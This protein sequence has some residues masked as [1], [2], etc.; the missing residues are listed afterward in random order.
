MGES[1]LIAAAVGATGGV[2][3][4]LVALAVWRF[5]RGSRDLGSDT[6]QATYRTLHLA[7][8]AAVHV[9][10]D[11]TGGQAERAARHLRTLLGCESLAIAHAAGVAVDGGNEVTRLAASEIAGMNFDDG[12]TRV[13][14]IA[15]GDSRWAIV[16]PI[17]SD[18]VVI[19]AIIAFTAARRAPLVRAT[20]EVSEWVA[21]QLQLGELQSSR[22]ALAEAEL[23]A[24]RSQI[25]PHF[26]YNALNAIA[27]FILTDPPHARD[28]VLEFADY[29]RYS[30]RRVGEFTTIAE[31][32][33]SI[34]S[35]LAIERA[36]F[37][38]RL[39]VSLQVAPEVLTAV[40]PFLSV[41][42][43]VENAVRHGLEQQGGGRIRIVA[44]E[45]GTDVLVTVEDNGSGIDPLELSEMLGRPA[46][47][48]HVGLRN[49]DARLR[50]VYG[51]Q[52]GLVIET[53]RGAGTLV[54]M[55][56]PGSQP[57]TAEV[58]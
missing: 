30:F 9:R 2:L 47:S 16:S 3:A 35:Y 25:S 41:Q 52:Y 33:H 12:R 39:A 19:G 1:L 56:V 45:I 36:R 29:T 42:P 20:K 23:R 50:R 54:R 49:V 38:K 48:D 55:T 34:D 53:N 4:T 18:S 37:G 21:A 40:I 57:A 7:S 11:L 44:K 17:I 28:L 8:K 31:E 6:E 14:P 32:L 43:L 5:A 26:I 24:L 15:A 10:E 13:L 58:K 46:A 51:E 27:S 22:V